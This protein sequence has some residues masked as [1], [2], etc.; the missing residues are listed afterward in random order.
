MAEAEATIALNIGSQ[1]VSMALFDST[2][3]GSLVLKNYASAS[4]LADPAAELTRLPQIRIAVE[5]LAQGLGV[6]KARVRYAI[7]G[8]TV[9]T[10][11]VKLPP[12][13]EDNLEQ[14]VEYEAQQHVPFPI[15]E[16]VW[17]WELLDPD[18]VEKEVVIV[19]IKGEALDELNDCVVD[20][21][22]VTAQVDAAP[23]ALF[24]SF[25]YNYPEESEPVLIIDVGAKATTLVYVEGNRFFTRSLNIGGAS[26]S[27]AIAKEYGISFAE[28]E[29]QKV[30]NGLVSLGAN[31]TH[32]LDEAVAGLATVIRNAAN[33]LPAE[34]SRT[35]NYYRSQHGGNAPTKVLLAGGGANLPY[36]SEFLEEKVKLPVEFF[37]PLARVS[38][39]KGV[40]VEQLSHEAHQ[41]G[42]LVGL[43]LQ[44]SEQAQVSI[45]LV[46]AAVQSSRDASKRRPYL[47]GA[48]LFFLGG[49]GAWAGFQAYAAKVAGVEA[50]GREE[51]R[52]VLQLPSSQLKKLQKDADQISS[53]GSDYGYAQKLRVE[54]IEVIKELRDDF[55]R[56]NVWVVDLQPVAGYEPGKFETA[57][58]VVK[59]GFVTGGYGSSQVNQIKPLN[60]G[61]RKEVMPEI[62]AVRIQGFWRKSSEMQN[63]VNEILENVRKGSK[64]PGSKFNLTIPEEKG[65]RTIPLRD[66]QIFE[67]FVTTISEDDDLAAPFSMILPLSQ[68]IPVK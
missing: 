18:G 56:D 35:N 28:A 37:N 2:K 66:D 25:R 50:D 12:I 10:R 6:D 59:D 17:D 30:T 27:S 40:D 23:M 34:I 65:D 29:T 41:L 14:L 63:A 62:N 5:E 36:L 7:P 26:L 60:P 49:L 54:W 19:A 15:D 53:V 57:Q 51:V 3:S 67:S 52:D 46:P 47:L 43:G 20:A 16:V 45:D 58:S 38:I 68:P 42:E 32:E 31:H 64:D 33:R 8:Q 1:R 48:A 22:L 21:G 44:G 61:T 24:N 39:G 55:A 11:F 13:E 4:V 9:F